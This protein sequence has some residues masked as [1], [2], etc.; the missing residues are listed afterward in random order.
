M[1]T[2]LVLPEEKKSIEKAY[3]VLLS[4]AE[5]VIPFLYRSKTE[6]QQSMPRGLVM[7][8]YANGKTCYYCGKPG[9][10]AGSKDAPICRTKISDQKKGI[11]R[12]NVPGVSQPEP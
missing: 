4:E 9:H 10:I 5:G 12:R 7:P 2:L 8:N 3:K 11:F 1:R 6:Q